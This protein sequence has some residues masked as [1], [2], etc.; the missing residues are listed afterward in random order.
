MPLLSKSAVPLYEMAGTPRKHWLYRCS[1]Q[2]RTEHRVNIGSTG[3]PPTGVAVWYTATATTPPTPASVWRERSK[4]H[5]NHRP[6]SPTE[7]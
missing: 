4:P 3:V 2:K 1:E 7:N 6:T 5:G